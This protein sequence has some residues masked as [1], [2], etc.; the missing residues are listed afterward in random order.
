M[1]KFI[2]ITATC[3]I[4]ALIAIVKLSTNY[5]LNESYKKGIEKERQEIQEKTIK[6]TIET[7]EAKKRQLKIINNNNNI[8]TNIDYRIEFM[9]SIFQE[10]GEG[11][12]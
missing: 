1:N 4:I 6:K 11:C 8:G 7:I 3:V 5:F 12:L 2:I 10:R 9:C